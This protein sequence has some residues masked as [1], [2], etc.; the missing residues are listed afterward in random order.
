MELSYDELKK[1]LEDIDNNLVVFKKLCKCELST[2]HSYKGLESNIVR[3][4]NDIDIEDDETPEEKEES[5]PQEEF[6]A[7]V[8]GHDLT[9]R[10]MAFT[11]YK[12][13]Q[14]NII[15]RS[16]INKNPLVSI[17][18]NCYNG[19]A[20]LKESIESVLSQTYKN[21]ELIFWDNK[22][23]RNLVVKMAPKSGDR[24]KALD[25]ALA[26]IERQ[27]GKGSIMT[28]GDDAVI[29][30]I[31]STSTGSIGLDIALGIG[32]LPKG[33]IIEIYGPESSGKTTQSTTF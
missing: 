13:I 31:E 14:S 17:I 30:G 8:E 21:W 22:C 33:R 23:P 6:G 29:P 15:V 27:F 20:Y 26:Q 3:I 1:L 18:M 7:G 10:N 25:S 5:S 9:G 24:Q 32:G 28:L 16:N 19:E 4:Y 12:K 2:I 11:T